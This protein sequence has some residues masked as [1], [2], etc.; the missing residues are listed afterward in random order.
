M[1]NPAHGEVIGV[2]KENRQAGKPCG[3]IEFGIDLVDENR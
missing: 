2:A 3:E 1:R